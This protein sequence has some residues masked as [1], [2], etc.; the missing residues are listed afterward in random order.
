MSS[1]G[2]LLVLFDYGDQWKRVEVIE[3]GE[4]VPKTRYPKV[5]K[6]MGKALP[7]YPGSDDKI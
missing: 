5:T 2:G 3:L 1:D 7:P 4:K 6:C